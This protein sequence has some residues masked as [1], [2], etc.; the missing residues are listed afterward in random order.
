MTKADAVKLAKRARQCGYFT[1]P[2]TRQLWLKCPQCHEKQFT[3][4]GYRRFKAPK[5]RPC[6]IDPVTGE[7]YIY[8]IERDIEALDR[9]MLD[10][11]EWC[12]SARG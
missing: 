1:D 8:R 12:G 5:G 2:D 10:H 6:N 4:A 3:E 7:H 11:L 9:M